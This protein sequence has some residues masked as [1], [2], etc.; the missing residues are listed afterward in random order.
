MRVHAAL[1]GSCAKRVVGTLRGRMN[2]QVHVCFYV[3]DAWAGAC[4]LLPAGCRRAMVRE[5]EGKAVRIRSAF[6]SADVHACSMI[7]CKGSVPC[8]CMDGVPCL[9]MD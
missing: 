6:G 8:L 4:V 2:G 5:H 7:P 3:R 9:C 1:R